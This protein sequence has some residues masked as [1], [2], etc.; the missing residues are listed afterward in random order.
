MMSKLIG[1]MT[2]ISCALAEVPK[3]EFYGSL[4]KPPVYILGEFYTE[5]DPSFTRRLYV[6]P[7]VYIESSS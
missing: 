5:V 6:V 3:T 2:V 1:V 7:T 4:M